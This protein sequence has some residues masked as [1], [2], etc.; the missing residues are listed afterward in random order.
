VILLEKD[1]V[2]G[3][4]RGMDEV[5]EGVEKRDF[6][7]WVHLILHRFHQQ[8]PVLNKC[9]LDELKAALHRISDEVFAPAIEKDFLAVLGISSGSR[10]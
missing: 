6:G 5:N 8:F 4:G 7:E 9:S 1:V 10:R 2:A 3:P